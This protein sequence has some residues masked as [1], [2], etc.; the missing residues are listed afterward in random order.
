MRS[1]PLKRLGRI[2]RSCSQHR[3]SN[4]TIRFAATLPYAHGC[5]PPHLWWCGTAKY[6]HQ[7]GQ[8]HRHQL[9]THF[10]NTSTH[11]GICRRLDC[12]SY[13]CT[14]YLGICLHQVPS[15]PI[16]PMSMHP[17]DPK[18]CAFA[19]FRAQPLG[20]GFLIRDDSNRHGAN[21]RRVRNR[22]RYHRAI[23]AW[24]FDAGV[25][26]PH[27]AQRLQLHPSKSVYM[28]DGR[29]WS[30][31]LEYLYSMHQQELPSH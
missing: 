18:I 11:S 12:S 30:P 22:P 20:H 8:Q 24:V 29:L 3:L 6:P 27:P 13:W 16:C 28:A 25:G 10:Q 26:T 4:P 19:I 21:D 5:G 23:P 14:S 9:G 1:G 15:P 2:V 31:H 7:C 17:A